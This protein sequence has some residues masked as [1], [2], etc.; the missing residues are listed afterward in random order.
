MES[1][2]RAKKPRK[3]SQTEIPSETPSIGISGV[4]KRASQTQ[5]CQ[6]CGELGQNR[7]GCK[8]SPP[9]ASN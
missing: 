2:S 4:G 8:E 1:S 6:K 5:T 7:K 9:L 3:S